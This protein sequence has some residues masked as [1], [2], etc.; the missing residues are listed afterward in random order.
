MLVNFLKRTTLLSKPVLNCK[1]TKPPSL[2]CKGES[3]LILPRRNASI[4]TR[5]IL[6]RKAKLEHIDN[7]GIF[8]L[9]FPVTTFGLGVW[10]IKRKIWKE[11]L[12]A[13]LKKQSNKEPVDLPEDLTQLNSMEYQTVKV[14]GHFLHDK[15]LYLGPRTL[16]ESHENGKKG[17]VLTIAPKS[18]Y[19]VVTPF[20]LNGREETIL[21]NRG[22]VS[23]NKKTPMS[24]S[25]GQIQGDV[26]IVGVVRKHE[27][28]PQFMPKMKDDNLFLYRDVN[29]MSAITGAEPY[30]LDATVYSNIS[31]GPIGGQTTITLR[32]EHLSYVVT[33]FSLSGLSA[34]FWYKMVYLIPK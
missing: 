34:W 31:G 2:L 6:I 28:R 22:W 32:N 21:V 3:F 10:Q 9:F 23:K 27:N 13:E 14:N 25:E 4:H 20:K 12:I 7:F 29:R 17:G 11:N 1:I 18:G 5:N 16:I 30:Y 33:W 19:L 8:L 15:E 24:R 26:E